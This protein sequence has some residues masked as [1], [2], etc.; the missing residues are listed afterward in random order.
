MRHTFRFPSHVQAAV[1][2]HVRRAVAAV[3][4]RQFRQ[5][6]VYIAA[7]ANRLRGIAYRGRDAQIVFESTVVDAYGKGAA[8]TWSGADVALTAVVSGGGRRIQKAI[9]VQAKM[10]TVADL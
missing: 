4:M 8:E 7:L 10:A 9:L 1:K 6:P 3:P 5:E 2:E